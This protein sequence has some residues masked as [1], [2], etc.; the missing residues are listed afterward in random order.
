MN[1][2]QNEN[3]EI[4]V[5]LEDNKP[6]EISDKSKLDIT[7]IEPLTSPQKNNTDIKEETFECPS[8]SS[9]YFRTGTSEY[10]WRAH[11]KTLKINVVYA[12]KPCSLI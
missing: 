8:C 4:L 1:T 6:E 9:K 11:T 10:I 5:I 2:L 12:Y 3:P 7:L